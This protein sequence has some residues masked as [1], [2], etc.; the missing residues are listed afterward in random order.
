MGY[1]DPKQHKYVIEYDDNKDNHRCRIISNGTQHTLAI[2]WGQTPQAAL[3][4]ALIDK[5]YRA[6]KFNSD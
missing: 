3:S 6:S 4:S 2:G 5:N 1:S